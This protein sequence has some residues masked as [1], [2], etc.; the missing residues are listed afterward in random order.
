MTS[1]YKSSSC[2]RIDN[3]SIARPVCAGDGIMRGELLNELIREFAVHL[4]VR[5]NDL[6]A[7]GVDRY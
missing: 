6:Q 4:K 2:Q 3:W 1:E 7:H 5:S